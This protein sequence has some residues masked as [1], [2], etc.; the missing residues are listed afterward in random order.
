MHVPHIALYDTKLYFSLE[1]GINICHVIYNITATSK[2]ALSLCLTLYKLNFKKKKSLE[3]R[4]SKLRS[5]VAGKNETWAIHEA[6]FAETIR[7]SIF[8]NCSRIQRSLKML[9][10]LNDTFF[11]MLFLFVP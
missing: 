1:N 6:L 5:I 2:L 11:Y 8:L 10:T 9:G 3:K 4:W 7:D